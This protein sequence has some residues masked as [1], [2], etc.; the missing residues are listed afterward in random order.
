[1]QT[2]ADDW[3]S[4]EDAY[5]ALRKYFPS[6]GAFKWHLV[7]RD[8]NGLAAADAVRKTPTHRLIVHVER[9]KRW[10]IAEP[11]DRDAA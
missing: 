7:R 4:I 1:M 3:L 11:S 10:A 2:E 9:V 6:L 8:R 5:P